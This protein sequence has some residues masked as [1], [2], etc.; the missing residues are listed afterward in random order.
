MEAGSIV[1]VIKNLVM[2]ALQGV[3]EI[4]PVSSSGHLVIYGSVLGRQLAFE[5]IIFLH[6]GTLFAIVFHYRQ[7][8][9][10]IVSGRLGWRLPVRML[11]AFIATAAVGFIVEISLAEPLVAKPGVVALLWIANGVLIGLAGK[12]SPQGERKISDLHWQQFLL[13][14]LIQGVSPLPGI[15]R[16]GVT[17]VTGLL[18]SL[19]WFE[20][21]KLSFLLSIPV[22][23]FA[24][25][26]KLFQ[27]VWPSL[28]PLNGFAATP[29]GLA[30]S[31][32]IATLGQ[33]LLSVALVS[34]AFITGLWALRVLA[35]FLS[36][37]LLAYFGI[38]TAFAGLFFSLYLNLM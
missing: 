10:Q 34:I 14:G 16:L 11:V 37:R 6:L 8:I 32:G 5:N 17:L 35:R 12:Y 18:F 1:D 21:L 33:A 23:F 20:A 31:L 29:G 2:A 9:A 19:T 15:S 28:L 30:Q 4:F 25:L 27:R 7:D 26:Y 38:Y 36:R 13:L 24:N 22:I 3:S